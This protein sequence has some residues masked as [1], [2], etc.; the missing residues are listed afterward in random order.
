M[1]SSSV[2]VSKLPI[3]EPSLCIPRVFPNITWKRV[4][5]ALED[6]GLG[7]IDRVDMV[8]KT[9]DKGEK[10]KRVFVHFK[11][12]ATTPEATAARE[13]VMAGDMFEITY[14]DPWFWKIGKSHAKKPERRT[15]KKTAPKKTTRPKLSIRTPK[16]TGPSAKDTE[17]AR[18]KNAMELQRRELEELR[19]QMAGAAGGSTTPC[20]VPTSPPVLDRQTGA[21]DFSIGTPDHIAR[22]VEAEVGGGAAE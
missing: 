18:I 15:Q 19:A 16:R 2:S 7:E 21:D 3:S 9:N 10:F 4:K 14:D 5:D 13:M 12:W 20:Y 11:K 22:E 8:N 1:A 6:V 17:L